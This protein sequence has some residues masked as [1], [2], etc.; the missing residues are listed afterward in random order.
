MRMVD[1]YEDEDYVHIITEKYDG[2]ELFDKIIECTDDDNGCLSEEKSAGIV[3]SLL[4]AVAYLHENDIV[5]RDIKPENILF[6][7][8]DERNIRLI[9][10]GLSRRHEKGD[11]YMSNPVGTAYYMSPELLKGKYGKS[12]DIW[13]VGTIV[14]ILLCGYPPFNGDTDSDIFENIKRGHFDFPVQ[15]WSD[16]SDEAKDFIKCLLRRDP[17]KRYTAALALDHPWIKNLGKR[18]AEKVQRRKVLPAMRCLRIPSAVGTEWYV[19][20][21]LT[22]VSL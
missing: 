20:S 4:E 1:C 14:Y 9:D 15:Q 22:L 11:R 19:R 21:V 2:G 7:S 5:H 12:T 17:R 13:S 10:F 16:K 8:E 3:K 18:Q 6:E